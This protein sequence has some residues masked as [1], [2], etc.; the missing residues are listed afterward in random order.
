MKTVVNFKV[1]LEDKARLEAIAKNKRLDVSN[2]IRLI[3]FANLDRFD[4]SI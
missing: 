2:M 1:D 3:L 4:K